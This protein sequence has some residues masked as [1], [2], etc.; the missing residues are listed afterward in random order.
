MPKVTRTLY[1]FCHYSP[2]RTHDS[3]DTEESQPT[4]LQ[5][6]HDLN[7]TRADHF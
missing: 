6:V 4:K 1:T 2:S 5:T 7:A 3:D